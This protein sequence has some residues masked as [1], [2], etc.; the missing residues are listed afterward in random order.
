MVTAW[1]KHVENATKI[2]K[3]EA[4]RPLFA[5]SMFESDI[6]VYLNISKESLRERT[7]KR[8]VAFET[9]SNYNDKIKKP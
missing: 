8:G 7:K 1:N 3:I 5:G 4:G 6:V 2:V 9:A